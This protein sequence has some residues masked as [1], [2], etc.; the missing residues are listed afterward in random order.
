MCSG[1]EMLRCHHVV[2]DPCPLLGVPCT[3]AA[4]ASC[5]ETRGP[6]GGAEELGVAGVVLNSGCESGWGVGLGWVLDLPKITDCPHTSLV[7]PQQGCPQGAPGWPL[8]AES[9]E[10]GAAPQGFPRTRPVSA[11]WKP[12]RVREHRRSRSFPHCRAC[13]LLQD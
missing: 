13:V 5:P 4:W 8:A 9:R 1:S 12:S 11:R 6:P 10:L 3:S 2:S 7:L